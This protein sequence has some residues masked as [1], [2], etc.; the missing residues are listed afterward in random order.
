MSHETKGGR[1]MIGTVPPINTPR[2]A[3]GTHPR[4]MHVTGPQ[5][6]TIVPPGQGMPPPLAPATAALP[7][8]IVPGA[9]PA[10]TAGPTVGLRGVAPPAAGAPFAGEDPDIVVGQ[11][12]CGYVIRRKLAEG[13]MGVVYEGVHAKIGR[14]GAIKVLKRE[15][16]RSED[17][18]ERF[19][20]EARA[21]NSIRHD[22]IV[23]I[24]DFGRD[25]YGRVFFVMEYLEGEPLSAR[26]GRGA[27]A[28]PEAFPILEQTLRALKAAH[29]KG[30][31]HRDLKPDNIW[32]KYVEGRVQVKLL[33]FG[34]AKLVGTESPR[35]KLTQTGSVIGTP[36]YMSP[37]QINGSRDVDHRTDIYALGVIT[38]EMFAGVTPF[39]G[40]TLQ[41]VMTGHLF[42]EPPRLAEL[43]THIT[44][45][46]P[47]AGLVDRV[48]GRLLA[49]DATGRYD[50]VAD[51]LA[52]LHDVSRNR[53]PTHADS[54]ERSRPLRPPTMVAG[55]PA[56]PTPP[57]KRRTGLIIGGAVAAAA[58]AVAGIA[59]SRSPD[60]APPPVVAITT[61]VVEHK[62]PPP[63]VDKTLD[64]DALRKDA[65][66]TMRA[67]LRETE[68]AVR[69]QGSDAL[70]KTKDR[71]AVPQ[72]TELT[73]QDPDQE[74]RG[75]AAG[76][77]G[78]IGA[79]AAAPLLV[80]LE[81]AAPA[82]LKVWYAS[83]LARLG[84]KTA[85]TRLFDYA[86]SKDL[87]VSFKAGITL[88]ELSR[89]G[90]KNA[91][92]ALKSIAAREA[93]LAKVEPY[94]GAIILTKMAGLRDAAARKVLYSILDNP[95]EGARLAAAEGLAR[96]GDDAGKPVL[97]AVMANL[98]SP[99]RLVAAVAQIPLGE[100]AGTQLITAALKDANP[101]T[102]RLAARALG[103]IAERT[104]LPQLIELAHDADWTVR[105]AAAAAIVSIVGIDPAV[106]AQASVDWTKSA[107]ESQDWAVR[108]AAAG[109][110]A[111]IPEKQAMPLLAQAIVDPDPKVRLAASKSAGKMKGAD[112]ATKVVAAVKAEADPAVKEQQ[113]AA[114]GA[115][116]NAVAHDTLAEIAE[117]PGRIGVIAA[118][119]LISV[120]DLVG[121]K[122]KLDAAVIAPEIG[123]RL[124]AVQA[125]STTNNAVVIPTLKIGLLDK[126]FDIKFTAAEGLAA[127]HAEKAA[128]MP[129]LTA[130]LQSK[131][132]EMYSRAMASLTRLGEKLGDARTPAEMIDAQDPKQRLAVVSVVRAMQPSEAVPLLRRLIAD[133]DQEVRHA[134]VDAIEVVVVK[135]KE[136]AIRLY[137]PL[138]NDG[139][140]FV[141]SKAAGQLSRLVPPPPAPSTTAGLT[142]TPPPPPPPLDPRLPAIQKELD[143]ATGAATEI[144]A[145]RD[146]IA[147][148]ATEVAAATKTPSRS[149]AT[150]KQV[151]SLATSLDE[152]AGQLEALAAKAETAAKAAAD[153]AGT[154]PSTDAK[155]L[156]DSTAAVAK[157][158]RAIATDARTKATK[159]AG[160]ARLWLGGETVDVT[161]DVTPLIASGRYGEAKQAL[162]KAA[163]TNHKTGAS[164]ASIDYLY[165]QLYDG[166]ARRA[167][168]DA[169]KVKLLKQA[170]E[171][172]RR[173]VKTGS[174]ARV[175]TANARLGEIPDDIKELGTH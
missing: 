18:V 32:L 2:P 139:D 145:A 123:I 116:G 161:A 129:V 172:Y 155:A 50:S 76:A 20:Q 130:G 8:T 83:A 58:I 35:E 150:I 131:D 4:P 19:Y 79:T 30:Y 57:R 54:L 56:L 112:A 72:L 44:I 40:D 60:V 10:Q 144:K 43:P 156:A 113:V 37:E 5:Q 55:A 27:L 104:S 51:V 132:P 103:D 81:A 115:I 9:G 171:A 26:I 141:R 136:Q 87:A 175:K 34:I 65:Q 164:N 160:D 96:L 38:Y 16:C 80:K 74:V 33:D 39:V 93:E 25:A 166:M 106:L 134:G 15:L 78:A 170:E 121:G 152:S 66:T 105:V 42:R 165:G 114:L 12:L 146:A 70:G 111:D 28:W 120:G 153:A 133:P 149:D 52:D 61:P 62:P 75:H 67:S 143:N 173:F 107:L 13:G 101:Q 157:D 6:P 31:V 21:V 97:A 174:G 147:R 124:A 23:D 137:R 154:P 109:V 163:A 159:A 64:Y 86:R 98:D 89:P 168:D 138:V 90:D 142:A 36:H 118:G 69:T 11:E 126:I 14:L 84:D 77:L 119:S 169:A 135:D 82:P 53:R 49:K 24:Y 17:V 128:V 63:P 29:D 22:N 148:Q 7:A 88:A 127:Q 71:P 46:G 102:R 85:T 151:E 162:D 117:Q 108:K 122:A 91:I 68:P 1:T 95:D 125:A 94:A 45:A 140:P 110:L 59:S 92:A 73:E 100:Y 3:S 99:N 41:A 48:L 158:T 167:K 47:M